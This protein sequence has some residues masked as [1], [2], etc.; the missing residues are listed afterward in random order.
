MVEIVHCSTSYRKQL[1]DA[2][3]NHS[4]CSRHRRENRKKCGNYV[5][6]VT[7]LVAVFHVITWR[8]S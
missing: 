2:V 5:Q 1:Y 4:A 6:K 7:L 8:G 3:V